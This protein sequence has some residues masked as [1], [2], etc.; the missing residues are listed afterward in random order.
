MVFIKMDC[1]NSHFRWR[2]IL[3]KFSDEKYLKLVIRILIIDLKKN[4]ECRNFQKSRILRK[5]RQER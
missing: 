4:I 5:A 1:G 2:V 3:E